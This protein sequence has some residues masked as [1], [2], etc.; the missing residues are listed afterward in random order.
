MIARNVC[1]GGE[2]DDIEA[3]ARPHLILR[4]NLLDQDPRVV[5][6]AHMNFQLR[7]D[8]PAYGLGFKRIPVERIGLYKDECRA[9]WPTMHN[10]E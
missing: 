4:D 3:K 9:S 5:D 2:W 8:S 7:D 1:V 6:A 10:R